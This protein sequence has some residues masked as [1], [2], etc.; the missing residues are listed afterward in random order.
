LAA[1]PR[2]EA[3]PLREALVDSGY[4]AAVIGVFEG[5]SDT[6]TIQVDP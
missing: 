6:P 4:A 2:S 5:E 3:E 1:V